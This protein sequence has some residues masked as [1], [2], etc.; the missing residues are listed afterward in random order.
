[1]P[2]RVSI[3]LPNL[4]HR[5]FLEERLASILGQTFTDWELII[6]D[7]FS[8]DGAWEF[9]QAAAAAD[10][11]IVAGQA[12]RDGIY[13]NWNRCVEQAQGEF[14]YFATSDDTMTPDF[15]AEMVTAL[16]AHPEC[17]LAQCCLQGID[18]HGAIIPG[19]WRLTGAARFLGDYYLRPHLRRAPYDGVLHCTMHTIYHSIT[20]LLIRR[21]TFARAGLFPNQYGPGGDFCWGMKAGLNCDVIHVPKFLATWR[22]HAAQASTGYRESA[23]ERALMVR[24]VSDALAA[25]PPGSPAAGLAPAPLRFTYCYEYHRRAYAESKTLLAK[26]RELVRLASTEP[27][28]AAGA[29]RL[30]L[31][32]QRHTVDRI[33]QARHLL[34]HFGLE[35]N[36]VLLPGQ[37]TPAPGP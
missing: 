15:L 31:S 36:L 14:V 34:N 37:A 27:R 22:I 32:G 8:D 24:M 28:V 23:A 3:L 1:M 21:R 12:P 11:R 18:E 20:Q 2:P 25:R 30:A 7:S 19:W 17:D 33:R 13:P 5:R 9:L 26:F 16:D 4:N 35:E 10:S 29:I 6:L